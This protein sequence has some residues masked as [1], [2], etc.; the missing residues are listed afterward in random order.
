MSSHSLDG[1][2]NVWG[3]SVLFGNVIRAIEVVWFLFRFL[4]ERE[5][6]LAGGMC[7]QIVF[8]WCYF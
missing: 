6:E 1:V 2:V 7:W 4:K 8:Y 3:D 5:V